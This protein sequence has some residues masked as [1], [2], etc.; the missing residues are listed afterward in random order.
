MVEKSDK[1]SLIDL[2]GSFSEEHEQ[3]SKAYEAEADS[4]WNS[5]SYD[6]K[7]LA[8]YSVVKRIYEGDLKQQGSYRYVLYDVFGFGPDSYGIGMDCGYLE[9][10]NAIMS[11][12][13]VKVLANHRAIKYK[14]IVKT[15]CRNKDENGNCSQHNL[16]CSYPDCEKE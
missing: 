2:L 4:W 11:P 16:Q 8:F 13:D 10:H 7:L 12:E 3:A 15:V 14:A 1:K 6:D 9:L 5:L